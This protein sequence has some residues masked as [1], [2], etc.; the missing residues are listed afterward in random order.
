MSDETFI[1]EF[2]VKENTKYLAEREE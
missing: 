1:C 2:I